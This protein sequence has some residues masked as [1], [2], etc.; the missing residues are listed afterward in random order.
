MISQPLRT[1]MLSA[2]IFSAGIAFVLAST[3]APLVAQNGGQVIRACVGPGGI[4]KMAGPQESCGNNQTLLTWN[5]NG[6]AGP[7]GST[8]PAGATGGM[9]PAGQDGRD[10]RDGRDGTTVPTAPPPTT[11]MELVIPELSAVPSRVLAF[12]WGASN[13]GT[14][15]GGSGGSTGRANFQDM[16]FT[17]LLDHNSIS[18]MVQISSGRILPLAELNVYDVS[19]G[20]RVLAGNYRFEVVLVTSVSLGGTINEAIN[21]L[22]ENVTLHFSLVR[23]SW[24]LN[25]TT[26]TSCY[27]IARNS[28]C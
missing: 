12:S 25:G 22:T 26:L 13:S 5:T 15:H 20:G 21:Q 14:T 11:E 7:A 27:D 8:G 3:A 9:G 4:V 6:P 2:A 1:R 17:K 28:A 18:L 24:N 10:G 19:G 16:S 23:S